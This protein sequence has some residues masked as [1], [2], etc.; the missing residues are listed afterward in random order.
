MPKE[1]KDWKAT[2][3]EFFKTSGI[4]TRDTAVSVYLHVAVAKPKTTKLRFPKPDVDNYAKSVLD[5]ATEAGVWDDDT[6]VQDLTV[7]KH[8]VD[9]GETPGIHVTIREL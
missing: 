7:S 9:E 8:W 1:Y 6:L 4:K 5:A 2:V 3:A